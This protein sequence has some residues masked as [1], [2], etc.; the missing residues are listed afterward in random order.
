MLSYLSYR[1]HSCWS[2]GLRWMWEISRGRTVCKV[3]EER[4]GVISAFWAIKN[5]FTSYFEH[6]ERQSILLLQRSI[7]G[8]KG[9]AMA[10]WGLLSA[11]STPVSHSLS[12]FPSCFLKHYRRDREQSTQARER[13]S[14][15]FHNP[16]SLL[17][18]YFWRKLGEK[19]E[20]LTMADSP[21]LELQKPA[22]SQVCVQQWLVQ[23]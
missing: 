3:R 17:R 2:W 6:W 7:G 1:V 19:Q 8:Q 13:H 21:S 9:L 11:S 18:F 16:F 5:R 22:V 20:A 4:E 12:P 15:P 23:I 10:L 14:S